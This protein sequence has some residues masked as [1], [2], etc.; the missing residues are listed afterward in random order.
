MKEVTENFDDSNAQ[1]SSHIHPLFA[2]LNVILVTC[3][4]DNSSPGVLQ[5]RNN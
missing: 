2:Y 3:Q 1:A 4:I 5:E